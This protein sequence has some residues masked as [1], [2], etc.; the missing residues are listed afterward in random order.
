MDGKDAAA[1][2][3]RQDNWSMLV[4]PRWQDGAPEATPPS[5]LIVGGWL[6]D[7]NG[8]AGP[9]QPNPDYEPADD[10]TP[11]DPTDAVLRRLAHGD[12]V[13]G[14][15]V[16]TLLDA[17][18]EIGCDEFD[19]P[20]VGRAPDGAPCVAVATAA[21]HKRRVEAARWWPIQGCELPGIVPVGVDILLNPGSPDQ[22]R[23]HTSALRPAA[24]DRPGDRGQNH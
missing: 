10:T 16:P 7:A 22:F 6:L 2:M 9:F 5:E 20:L 23:L 17:V 1:D 8:A 13:G 12:D 4:D 15:I 18:V 24:T 3:T 14:E 11:T 19:E 21:V